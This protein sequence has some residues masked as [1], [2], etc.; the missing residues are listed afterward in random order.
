MDTSRDRQPHSQ[1]GNR[2]EGHKEKQQV[3]EGDG[4]NFVPDGVHTKGRGLEQCSMASLQSQSC[5]EE[6]TSSVCGI[7]ENDAGDTSFLA[8]TKVKKKK[9]GK[10]KGKE[11]R[12]SFIY[13][14]NTPAERQDLWAY[15]ISQS[16]TMGDQAWLLMGDFNATM[17]AAD[18]YGGDTRWVGHKQD[19]G[20]CLHQA[21][22]QSLPYRGLKYTWH[23]G[24]SSQR[25]ILKKL[26]WVRHDFKAPR[27]SAPPQFQFKFLS[28]WTEQEEFISIIESAW[29]DPM[30][31]SAMFKLTSKLRKVKT[32]LSNWHRHHRSDIKGRV[33]KAKEIWDEAQTMVDRAPHSVTAKNKEREAAKQYQQLSLDEESYYKQ[34]SRIQWLM[35][36]KYWGSGSEVFQEDHGSFYTSFRY[37]G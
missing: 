2:G 36:E 34:K 28:L 31:G 3:I 22:L 25:M 24:Q 21:Q 32:R 19:F 11:T 17:K 18:S 7:K 33:A 29:Q 1:E 35:L 5:S 23:N 10:Q 27:K 16:S 6:G 15:L 12:F 37:R 14:L 30:E 26:D 4:G 13:G 9:G 8:Y 20:Q